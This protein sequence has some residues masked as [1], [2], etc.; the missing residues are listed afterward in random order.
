MGLKTRISS[1]KLD[2]NFVFRFD[3]QPW[4]QM[5]V[6]PWSL[7]FKYLED[8]AIICGAKLLCQ[9]QVLSYEQQGY[10]I[11]MCGLKWTD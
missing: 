9:K 8:T 4:L 7:N 3:H 1:I 11:L 10:K 5:E 2:Y 6:T